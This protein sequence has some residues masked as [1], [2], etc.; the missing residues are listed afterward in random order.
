MNCEYYDKHT[1]GKDNYTCLILDIY[2]PCFADHCV[3]KEAY[4]RGYAQ[5]IEDINMEMREGE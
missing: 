5:H 2:C 3:V 1:V 4:D